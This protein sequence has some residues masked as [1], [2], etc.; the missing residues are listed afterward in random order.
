MSASAITPPFPTFTDL[1][2]QP[3]EAGYIWIGVENLPPQTNPQTAY[4]DEALTQ[5]AAQPIRTSG[6][7]PVNNGT[8]AALYAPGAYSILVQDSRGTLVYSALAETVLITSN[9]VTFLQAG[10]GAVTRTAQSKMRDVVSVKDFGAVG[11]GVSDDT[12]DIQAALSSGAKNVF[13][14]DGATYLTTGTVIVPNEVSI[15]FGTSKILYSGTR[16]RAAVQFGNNNL[17]STSG[18]MINAWVESASTDVSNGAFVGIKLYNV[19]RTMID[20]YRVAGFTHNVEFV[21]RGQGVTGVTF[22]ARFLGT[23]KYALTTTCDG[24]AFNY[25]NGNSFYV[26]DWTNITPQAGDSSGWYAR[27]IAGAFTLENQN[28]NRVHF[29]GIQPGNGSIGEVR[30]ACRLENTGSLNI[31]VI[32]RYESGRGAIATIT[33]PVGDGITVDKVVAQNTFQIGLL[34]DGGGAIVRSLSETISARLNL[35]EWVN[36]RSYGTSEIVIR[37]LARK[38]KAYTASTMTLQGDGHVTDNSGNAALAISPG[39]V[40]MAADHIRLNSAGRSIGFFVD[41]EGGETFQV[42]ADVVSGQTCLLGIA[43]YDASGVRISYPGS[44]AVP[45]IKSDATARYNRWSVDMGGAFISG[46]GSTEMTFT[47]DSTVKRLRVFVYGGAGWLRAFGLRRLTR[48][49]TPLSVSSGL[50]TNPLTHYVA[51]DPTSGIVGIYGRGDIALLDSASGAGLD[52]YQ[53]TVGGYL[54]EAW[55]IS[56]PVTLGMLRHNGGNVYECTTAGTTAG[57]GGPSGTGSGIVDNTA[58]WR[59]LSAKAVAT[60]V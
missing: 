50:L 47:A 33:G 20:V 35:I 52:A 36:D 59:Y 19:Q 28:G 14:G 18:R 42:W 24:A 6:G 12:V 26:E 1:D 37:D 15:D 49:K 43:A 30:N 13:L 45:V 31:I 7:Y 23:C 54:C 11:D 22:T 46:A 10:T 55:T 41:I 53:F 40:T 29:H 44:P 25:I 27:E 39:G 60:L 38:L 57:A 9:I 48:S 3:L 8:P 17:A 4:W 2:G 34:T 51:G 58:V 16:D 56:T 32:D 21:S 5:P